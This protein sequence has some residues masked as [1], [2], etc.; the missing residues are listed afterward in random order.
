MSKSVSGQIT[1]MNKREERTTKTE[2]GNE[3]VKK[4]II[5]NKNGFRYQNPLTIIF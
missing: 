4:Q 3:K 1:L 2:L 5:G